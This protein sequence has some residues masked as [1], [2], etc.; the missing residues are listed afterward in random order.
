MARG[1]PNAPSPPGCSAS[2]GFPPEPGVFL[3]R[4]SPRYSE[5]REATIKLHRGQ[6]MRK[7]KA[8][9]LPELVRFAD[10][11]GVSGA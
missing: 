7:M 4:T 2:A 1:F 10:R 9:S 5:V 3:Q 11:L 8:R 6:I